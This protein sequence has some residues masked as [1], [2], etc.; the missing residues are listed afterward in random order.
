MEVK[1]EDEILLYLFYKINTFIPIRLSFFAKRYRFDMAWFGQISTIL[2]D[3]Y[4]ALN[5]LYIYIVK[6]WVNYLLK[7]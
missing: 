5:K 3:S 7:R 6:I 2:N 1:F 4:S